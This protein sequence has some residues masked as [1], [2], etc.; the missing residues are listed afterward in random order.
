MAAVKVRTVSLR[1]FDFGTGK[2]SSYPVENAYLYLTK[3]GKPTPENIAADRS[4]V[5]K[6]EKNK[7][8]KIRLIG[9][10]FIPKLRLGGYFQGDIALWWHKMRVIYNLIGG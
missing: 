8:K 9:R 6:G 7:H 10:R 4:L 5:K 3:A 2:H 1:R